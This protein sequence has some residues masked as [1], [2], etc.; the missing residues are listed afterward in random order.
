MN[1][2][3]KCWMCHTGG[4]P[5]LVRKD[6]KAPL[7]TRH[8]NWWLIRYL[9]SEDEPPCGAYLIGSSADSGEAGR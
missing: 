8:W 9:N 2:D 1:E 4:L 3:N 5:R 7:C 6:E